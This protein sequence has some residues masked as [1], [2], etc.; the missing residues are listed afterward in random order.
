M[1]ATSGLDSILA[2]RPRNKGRD[3]IRGS[4]RPGPRRNV[5]G[6]F[7]DVLPV[8]RRSTPDWTPGPCRT[9]E[10]KVGSWTGRWCFRRTSGM[11]SETSSLAPD[12]GVPGLRETGGHQ[13][14][15]DDL[16]GATGPTMP[17]REGRGSCWT[18]VSPRRAS[19]EDTFPPSRLRP[20]LTQF[21]P[22][23]GESSPG[24]GRQ[25]KVVLGSLHR[26]SPERTPLT[27]G[28]PLFVPFL[29]SGMSYWGYLVS[30]CARSMTAT[31][32]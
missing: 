26:V 10:L 24:P 7:P 4:F 16:C 8:T 2:Q 20:S 31:V 17:R 18:S 19:P 22:D 29:Q 13:R 1:G 15:R 12:L 25:S 14:F 32:W 23:C 9:V 6:V 5:R 28:V 3:L 27:S 30:R 21:G 11:R